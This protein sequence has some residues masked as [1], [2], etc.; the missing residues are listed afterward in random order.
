VSLSVVVVWS[1]LDTW[2][3]DS[4]GIRGSSD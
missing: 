2:D 1:F 3:P 4:V